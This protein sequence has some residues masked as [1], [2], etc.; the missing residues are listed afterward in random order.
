MKTTKKKKAAA[1]GISYTSKSGW[2][3]AHNS[4][5]PVVDQ[6]GGTNGFR[7]FWVPPDPKWKLCACGWRSDLGPHYSKLAE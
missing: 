4:V 5:R 7:R 6:R 2:L 3:L 1:P